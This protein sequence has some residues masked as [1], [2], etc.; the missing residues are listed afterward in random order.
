MSSRTDIAAVPFTVTD[1]SAV[2]ETIHLGETGTA[3][4]R[5][6]QLGPHRVRMVRYSPNYKADHWCS[7]GHILLIL[8]GELLTETQD[9]G[10]YRLTTGQSYEVSD[11]ISPHRSVTD[12]GALLF[13]VD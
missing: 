13:I 5:T 7:R 8:E 10:R 2:P 11:G 3:S 12:S 4:W 1:W 9:G 6:V